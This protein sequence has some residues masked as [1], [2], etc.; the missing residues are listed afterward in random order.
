[1]VNIP[2]WRFETAMEISELKLQQSPS[3][4]LHP[5]S[6]PAQ[7]PRVLIV[8]ENAS[9][10]FGGEAI[11]PLHYFRLL[12]Q[13]GIEA[14]LVVNHRTKAELDQ[15]LVND[16]DRITYVPDTKFHQWLERIAKPFPPAIKHFT[17]RFIGRLVSGV[18]A[19]RIVRDLVAKYQIDVVHQPTPVSPKEISLIDKVG[20]PVIIGP[21]NGGITYPPGFE[22]FQRGWIRAFIGGGRWV[23]Q[24][25]NRLMPGKLRAKTLL[26]ANQRT[27][28]ALPRGVRGQVTQLVENGVDLTI[29]NPSERPSR[30]ANDPIRFVF[31]GRLVDWK[32]VQY[33]IE[34]FAAVRREIPATLQIMGNG[35]MRASLESQATKA[36]LFD[37]VKFHG[38]MSQPACAAVLADADVF[39]LPSLYECGGAVVL[40]AMASGLP[41]IATNWGGPADYLDS[42]CGILID[43]QSPAVFV[44][45]LSNAMLMLAKDQPRRHAMGKSG[46]EKVV[47][48]FD[49]QRKIDRICE[50][51]CESAVTHR[52]PVTP[53]SPP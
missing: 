12:R 50:I 3:S 36:G 15:V 48:E 44:Q 17:F 32:G 24:L 46:R 6:S 38:W 5:P 42:S 4:I 40:E 2:V 30:G 16:L 1:V 22:S 35:P 49:W 41:V 26:V 51:Y 28:N 29:W 7:A 13:R 39:V 21:M 11:L 37:Y 9:A 19:R 45:Q 31:S 33:L 43:P 18:N 25:L 52:S 20:A 27:A 14:W 8:A 10:K 47:R 23:S 34:A 53:F